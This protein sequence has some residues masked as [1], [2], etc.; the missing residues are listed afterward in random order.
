M[1]PMQI[2]GYLAHAQSAGYKRRVES[3]MELIGRHPDYA[4]SC[5]WG[6]DSLCVLHMA[7]QA[8]GR[9]T[10]LH[11]R[12]SENEELPDMPDVRQRFLDRFPQV[13]YREVSVWG[14]WEIYQQ[15]G[16]FFLEPE[17]PQE[18]QILAD[19]HAQLVTRMDDAMLSAGAAGKILGLAAHESRGRAMNVR[20]RGQHY[21]TQAEALPKLLP[22]AHW[23]P[24]DVWAY[25]LAHDLP[26]LR[27]YDMAENPERAR[28][29]VA[30]AAIGAGADAI[31]R[32]GA[33]QEWRRCY[34][35]LWARW[36][37]VWPEIARLA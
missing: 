7:I 26:R 33:W 8:H 21:Q 32:H 30:F 29:E 14:D 12:Y 28:S 18:R 6:K 5:S 24:A 34:P 1:T 37:A 25:M 20:R 15:A 3:A 11:A 4:V 16:R 13:D 27:I 10:A 9:A 23:Q 35:D 2:A 36:L 22:I 31:R 19:W 17:T